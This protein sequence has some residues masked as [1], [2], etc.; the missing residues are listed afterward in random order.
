MKAIKGLPP[1]TL[2]LSV[3]AAV[4]VKV[5]S[6]TNFVNAK[7]ILGVGEDVRSRRRQMGATRV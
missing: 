2:P 1:S 4:L 7:V 5:F 3:D 6:S